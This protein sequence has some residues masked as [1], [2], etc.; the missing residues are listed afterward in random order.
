[1]I[2]VSAAAGYELWA[3][4]WDDTLSPIVALEGRALGPWIER[5]DPR[6]AVDVGCGT[7]RWAARLGAIGIDASPAMLAIAAGKL[8]LRGRL[9]VGD[10]MALP[11]ASRSADLVLCTLTLGHVRDQTAAMREFA[12]ILE[13]GGTLILTDFHPAAAAQG[14]RRTFRC[15]GQVYELE[16]YPYT[17]EQLR[18]AAVDLVNRDCIDATIGEPERPLF[19]RAGKRELFAAA[20]GTPAVL[21][22]RWERT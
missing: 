9:V 17:V 10:A 15:E 1:V 5:L 8:G 4:T 6:R 7:G 11:V 12:R 2:R 13:P 21:L 14:W 16:N 19:D 3:D 22:T 18:A 20:C